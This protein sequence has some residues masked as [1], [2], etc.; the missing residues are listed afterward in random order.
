MRRNV[1]AV[2]AA[3]LTGMSGQV[4]AAGITFDTPPPA[5]V[6]IVHGGLEWIWAA[7]CAPFD[8]SCGKPGSPPGT[9]PI[10]G[11]DI[12]TLAD[13]ALWS[14]RAEL[15]AAFTD[16]AGAAICG[17]PWL[18]SQFNHCDRGDAVIGGI[19]GANVNGICDFAA[20]YCNNSQSETFLVRRVPE[21]GNLVLLASALGVAGWVSRRRERNMRTS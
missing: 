14:D 5:S 11:F 6:I 4:L 8:P 3:F 13:W 2:I 21:P 9:F 18:S 17:S 19:W 20:G 12:P 10:Q 7:P 15:L 1:L 16:V